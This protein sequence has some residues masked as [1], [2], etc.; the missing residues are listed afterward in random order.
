MRPMLILIAEPSTIR[1][2]LSLVS[3]LRSVKMRI[4]LCNEAEQGVQLHHQISM[5][6]CHIREHEEA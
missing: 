1:T 4:I 2:P 6:I 5:I 3:C